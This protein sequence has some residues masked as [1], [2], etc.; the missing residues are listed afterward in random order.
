LNER[1]PSFTLSLKTGEKAAIRRSSLTQHTPPTEP[2]PPPQAAHQPHSTNPY[3]T[4]Q[5]TLPICRPRSLCMLNNF[6]TTGEEAARHVVVSIKTATKSNKSSGI[7]GKSVTMYE[8]RTQFVTTAQLQSTNISSI[9]VYMQ[10]HRYSDFTE[11]HADLV[12]K[13]PYFLVPNLPPKQSNL[14]ERDLITRQALLAQWLQFVLLHPVIQQSSLTATFVNGRNLD[15]TLSDSIGNGLPVDEFLY[16]ADE[17]DNIK[18]VKVAQVDPAALPI[19]NKFTEAERYK[20]IREMH[21]IS[22]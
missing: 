10:M 16:E 21:T 8:V 12:K 19:F 9:P 15:W 17:D 1:I 18:Q 22:R 2:L 6:S 3:A 5:T 11:Y 20:C 13:F 14:S 7:F 4:C